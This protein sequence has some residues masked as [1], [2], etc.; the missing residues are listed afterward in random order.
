VNPPI[1]MS[2]AAVERRLETCARSSSL[3]FAPLPRVDMSAVAVE[4]R[5]QEW[6]ELSVFCLA[7]ARLGNDDTV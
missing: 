1:D 5:L 3:D 4:G 2:A 6:A 7:L